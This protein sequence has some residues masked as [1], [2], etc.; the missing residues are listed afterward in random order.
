[1]VCV[2]VEQPLRYIDPMGLWSIG[3]DIYLGFGGGVSFGVDSNTG[4]PFVNVRAGWG[5]GGNVYYDPFGSAGGSQENPNGTGGVA[6]GVFAEGS[7]TASVGGAG[8]SAT[9]GY[10]AGRDWR[11]GGNNETY[12]GTYGSGS[13]GY[14]PG[15]RTGFG[16]SASRGVQISIHG[17]G[18]KGG[19]GCP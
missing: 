15:G 4:A 10:E 18:R 6:T 7:A 8:V 9:G 16:A 14:Q 13:L 2:C 1:M 11:T 3:F 12:S 17:P 5:A 19:K